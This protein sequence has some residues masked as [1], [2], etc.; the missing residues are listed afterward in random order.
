MDE[1][2]ESVD[3]MIESGDGP[4][5]VVTTNEYLTSNEA[6]LSDF[7]GL[8]EIRTDEAWQV[9]SEDTILTDGYIP[10]NR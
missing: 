3:E 1:D 2:P 9:V 5:E 10:A 8:V 7:R 6:L 4:N